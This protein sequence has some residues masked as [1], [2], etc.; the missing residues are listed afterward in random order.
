MVATEGYSL[1]GI[2]KEFESEWLP[3]PAGE[4]Y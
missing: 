4:W 2:K 1:H 3:T